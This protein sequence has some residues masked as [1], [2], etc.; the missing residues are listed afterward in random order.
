MKNRI[1]YLLTAALL[2]SAVGC[3]KDQT[4]GTYDTSS[5]DPAA[6]YFAQKN[7]TDEFVTGSTGDQ[8]I[9]VDIYRASSSGEATVGLDYNLPSESAGFFTIPESVTFRDGEFKTSFDITVHQVDAFAKGQSYTAEIAVGDHHDF[10]SVAT[11]EELRRMG[12]KGRT[13]AASTPRYE[14]ITVSVSLQLLWEQAYTPVSWDKMT[15]QKPEGTDDKDWWIMEEGA[16]RPL[17]ADLY[18]GPLDE[19][20]APGWPQPGLNVQRA[21]GTNVYRLVSCMG[22]TNLIFTIDTSE[23]HMFEDD[24]SETGVA[25]KYMRTVISPQATGLNDG[26]GELSISDIGSFMGEAYYGVYPSIWIPSDGL[27]QCSSLKIQNGEMDG[28]IYPCYIEFIAGEPEPEPAVKIEYLGLSVSELGVASHRLSFKPNDDAASYQ[29]TVLK[30]EI[31]DLAAVQQATADFLIANGVTEDH[32]QWNDYFASYYPQFLAEAEEAVKEQL[33]AIGEQIAAGTY[34]GDYPVI[35]REA[36]SEDAW[37]L[38]DAAGYFT[39]VAFSRTEDGEY[40]GVDFETFYYNPAGDPAAIAY[41]AI[42]G[43]GGFGTEDDFTDYS[44]GYFGDNSIM[45]YVTGLNGDITAVKYAVVKQSDFEAAGLSEQSTDKELIDYAEANGRSLSADVLK[46]VN[47]TTENYLNYIFAKAEAATDYKVIVSVSNAD[48]TAVEVQDVRTE[49]AAA[50]EAPAC[51]LQLAE[52][53]RRSNY[54]HNSV[55]ASFSGEHLVSGSYL[56]LATSS[57]GFEASFTIDAQGRI[58]KKEGVSDE[59]IVALIQENGSE[60]TSGDSESALFLINSGEGYGRFIAAKPAS[61]YALLACADQGSGESKWCS[62]SVVTDFA[63]A[64]AFRQEVSAVE[65]G[66][67]FTWSCDASD[68]IFAVTSV[69]Y[70]LI[71]AS[72]LTAAGVDASKLSDEEL[73]DFDARQA[74]G[75]S[76]AEIEAQRANAEKLLAIL[77]AQGKTFQ[78]GAADAINSPEG[79]VKQFS[80]LAAGDYALIALASDTYNTRLTVGQASV[81]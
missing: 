78:G 4:V 74:A 3:S 71:P 8:T 30:D 19:L 65:G 12:G 66:I 36:E 59:E 34:Q 10:T 38:G 44:A 55:Y 72:E 23:E 1:A 81:Q 75:A 18:W 24:G 53:A 41:F 6:A 80:G 79:V 35:S 25:G 16:P 15:E 45:L 11:P 60:F 49:A 43:A 50:P 62:A 64:V 14:S 31:L 5:E 54:R 48:A 33:A 73:N 42:A 47:G 61:Q 26:N 63:P 21:S 20:A 70:A 37:A 51:E 46:D 40:T 29:A 9:A 22:G 56:L 67:R 76:A 28:Y 7:Y 2:L 69:R 32:P 27:I 52:D 57:A 17:T 58:A 77:A 68:D 13:R 39:A